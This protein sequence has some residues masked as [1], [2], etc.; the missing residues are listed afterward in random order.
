[1]TE[2][3]TDLER[4]P[5]RAHQLRRALVLADSFFSDIR[6]VDQTTSTN[7]D[8]A[9]RA[10]SGAAEGAVLIAESQTGGRGRL[11][12]SWTAPPRAGL[13]FSVLFRPAFPPARWSWLS[14]MASV[15]VAAPL[16]RLS[17]LDVR[18]KWPNDVLVEEQKVA[19]ILAER[20]EDAVVLGIG[21]NVSQR[22]EELPVSS[23]TSLVIAGS[24]V[25]DRDPLLRSVLRSLSRLYSELQEA[26]GDPEAA[27][28]RSAYAG[29]CATLGRDVRVELPGGN[30]LDGAAVD[31]DLEGRLV[32]RR[33]TGALEQVAAGDVVH[34]R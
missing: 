8:L 28:L 3:W 7:A 5:L 30:R 6:V 4:P 14:L 20:V 23:A 11:D 27:G 34:V 12:R 19:G 21:L 26:N 18:V 15:A 10:R 31:V 2:N 29:M 1:V 22:R 17:G 32:V 25:V 9:G 24:E 13:T 33:A 16:G